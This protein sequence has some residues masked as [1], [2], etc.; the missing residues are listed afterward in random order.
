MKNKNEDDLGFEVN[1]GAYQPEG[2]L[3]ILKTEKRSKNLTK[4]S[5]EKEKRIDVPFEFIE[6]IK[7]LG[8]EES[9][10]GILYKTRINWT[11]VYSENKIY[12]TEQHCDFYTKIDNDELTKHMITVHSYGENPCTHPG[13]NFVGISKKNLNLHARMHTMQSDK[14]FWYKCPKTTCSSSFES[15]NKLKRHMR[16]HK[17]KTRPYLA[18]LMVVKASHG[19]TRQVKNF[20]LPQTFF[21]PPF[22]FGRKN[23]QVKFAFGIKFFFSLALKYFLA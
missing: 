23:E 2:K 3:K 4:K 21:Q 14:Q 19:L 10:A 17:S 8:M 7:K 16:I 1:F 22:A 9:D 11:E 12:C 15:E 5:D 18:C 13:C 6:K 20:R